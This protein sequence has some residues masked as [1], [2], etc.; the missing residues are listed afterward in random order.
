MGMVENVEAEIDPTVQA[1]GGVGCEGTEAVVVAGGGEG[2]NRFCHAARAKR[3]GAEGQD[4]RFARG[5][6]YVRV[7]VAIDGKLRYLAAHGEG[8]QHGAV[9]RKLLDRFAAGSVN[10]PVAI[11]AKK[12]DVG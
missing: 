3:L 9:R 11:H 1:S 12:S 6:N 2:R 10:M 8:S 4:L 7:A 5:Q